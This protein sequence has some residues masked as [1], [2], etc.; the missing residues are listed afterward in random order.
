MS[1]SLRSFLLVVLVAPFLSLE[2]IAQATPIDTSKAITV[3]EVFRWPIRGALTKP[4]Y[5]RDYCDIPGLNL[6][7]FLVSPGGLATWKTT[8]ALDTTTPLMK[9]NRIGVANLSFDYDGVLPLEHV[10]YRGNIWRNT[11]TATP[12][13]WEQ[14]DG[15]YRC[16]RG[17]DRSLVDVDG[18]G[19]LD[20]VGEPIRGTDPFAIVFGGKDRGVGCKRVRTLPRAWT[21]FKTGPLQLIRCGDGKV[22]IYTSLI[23]DSS[24]LRRGLYLFDV[25]VRRRDTTYD[26][27]YTVSDS[28]IVQ[29]DSTNDKAWVMEPDIIVDDTLHG[30]QYAL[31]RW[32]ASYLKDKNALVVY[33]IT[34]GKFIEREYNTD[35]YTS[36]FISPGYITSF[37]N[38]F[39]DGDAI[40]RYPRGRYYYYARI[41]DLFTPFARY[42]PDSVR[43]EQVFIDDQ[44][45]DG[46]RDMLMVPIRSDTKG[47]I[48]L[49]DFNPETSSTTPGHAP[50]PIRTW[51]NGNQ[52][53]LTLDRPLPVSIDFID[54]LGRTWP[55]LSGKVTQAG[56]SSI[57][58]T[59]IP[60]ALPAG[61]YLIRVHTDTYSTTIKYLHTP[62]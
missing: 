43:I 2:V 39:D 13:E 41:T 5:Y 27:S 40:V 18:D 62:S 17:G 60:Y 38:T 51:L 49:L 58:L 45:G 35:A 52:L 20:I 8:P 55:I 32:Q 19:I 12:F 61:P 16:V 15:V 30:K 6:V 1:F 9:E 7:I 42:A 57:D 47:W 59:T 3:N 25:D 21:A 31:C 14:C 56:T 24:K 22:R 48:A 4:S 37:G 23:T 54:M 26:I 50:T 10:D 11:D 44:T 29:L 36:S 33:D 28:I 53:R 34:N 46:K